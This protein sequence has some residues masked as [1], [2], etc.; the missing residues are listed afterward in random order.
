[1]CY[2]VNNADSAKKVNRKVK[3]LIDK[4]VQEAI[5]LNGKASY[6]AMNI[7]KEEDT[8]VLDVANWGLVPSKITNP[9]EAIK[10]RE[11]TLNAKAETIFEKT[12]FKDNIIPHR[13]LVPVNGFYEWRDL[14]GVKYPY[15]ITA[16]FD[17]VFYLAG[18][19]D[20]WTNHSTGLTNCTFSII[21][22]ESNK[23][24]SKIHNLK[25]RQPL[26]LSN[27]DAD[28]WLKN[29]L[30]ESDIERLMI[31]TP[32]ELMNAHTIQRIIPK[33]TDINSY[34]VIKHVEYP[35]LNFYDELTGE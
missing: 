11:N 2:S 13:C 18:I 12:S 32:D 21:T 16:S 3:K 33:K 19:Y 15:Y 23:L 34:A 20:Y 24:M 25:K 6:P 1:M 9:D 30:M 17:N 7:I 27:E 10:W 31:K 28:R 35:E 5:F 22:T 8:S 29:D 4:P 14:N 26:M